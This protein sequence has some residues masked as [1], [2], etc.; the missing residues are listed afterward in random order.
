MIVPS[1]SDDR[2]F[3]PQTSDLLESDLEAA[4]KVV[5]DYAEEG[6]EVMLFFK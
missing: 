1:F 4:W 2:P 6:R 3:R 5:G